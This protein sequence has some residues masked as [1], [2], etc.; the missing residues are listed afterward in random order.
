[1]ASGATAPVSAVLN[2][3][4]PL[5]CLPGLPQIRPVKTPRKD[6]LLSDSRGKSVP[7]F[8]PPIDAATLTASR[9]DCLSYCLWPRVKACKALLGRVH[10]SFAVT[11]ATF[12][13]T[14][15]AVAGR[16]GEASL[17]WPGASG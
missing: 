6:H 9:C 8:V 1:M 4:F 7:S 17:S 14:V 15:V 10:V 13:E 16:L 3:I 12:E 11:G 5:M 2:C